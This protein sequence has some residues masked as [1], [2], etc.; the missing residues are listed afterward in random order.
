MNPRLIGR[1]AKIQDDG[2]IR[3]KKQGF[4][5]IYEMLI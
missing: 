5:Y 1:T 3:Y 2:M 4:Q